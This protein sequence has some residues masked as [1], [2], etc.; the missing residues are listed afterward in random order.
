MSKQIKFN[1]KQQKTNIIWLIV[2]VV[3]LCTVVGITIAFFFNSDWANNNIGMSGKVDILAVGDGDLTIEDTYISN[4]EITLDDEY[5]VLI[6]GMDISLP[7][8]VKVFKS[9]TKPLLRARLDVELLDTEDTEE[10]Q[11]DELRVIQDLYGQ[12]S[13][14]IKDNGWYLHIDSWFYFVGNEAINSELGGGY[15]L[16]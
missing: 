15:N 14:T 10:E 1:G 5:D 11:N 12:L 8:N 6:P 7:A 9:T 2:V 4:L 16:I 13:D 3:S